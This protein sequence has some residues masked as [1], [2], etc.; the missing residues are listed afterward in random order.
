[1]NRI[2]NMWI[3]ISYKRVTQI[4]FLVGLNLTIWR[5]YECLQK[6]LN[7]NLST[8]VSMVKS[9]ETFFPSIVICPT[10][11]NAYNLRYRFEVKDIQIHSITKS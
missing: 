11:N 2:H 7:Q 8:K 6:Y 10:E 3:N 5:S 4:L 9:N 1:M